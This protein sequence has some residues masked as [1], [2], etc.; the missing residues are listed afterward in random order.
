MKYQQEY[1]EQSA[2]RYPESIAVDDHGDV[3]NYLELDTKANKLANLLR[4]IKVSTNDR[5]CLY[6]DKNI[7]MYTSV[8]G[9]LKSGGCWV[10]FSSSFPEERV[11]FLLSTLKPK[12]VLTEKK[13]LSSIKQFKKLSDM[14]FSIIVMEELDEDD[15]EVFDTTNIEEQSSERPKSYSTYNDLAYIIFTSGSTGT[16][17]GVMVEHRNTSQFLSLSK[18]YFKI[19]Q[20]SR[21][22]HFSELTFDPS[23]FD[24]FYCW[25]TAG[26][27]VPFNKKKYKINPLLFFQE[28]N[29]NVLF[30]VPGV[31]LNISD[32]GQL[33]NKSLHT[34]KHLLL[35][36][37]AVPAKLISDWYECHPESTVYNMYGTTETAI[38]S[39][40]YK[41]P[42]GFSMDSEVPVGEVL[43]ETRVVLIENNK[44]VDDGDVGECVVSSSQLSPGY[45]GNKFLTSKLFRENIGNNDLPQKSYW[46]GDLLRKD[47]NDLYYY[48]G[49][50]DTQLKI[51][52]HRVELGEVENTIL[53]NSSVVEAVVLP[54]KND[55]KY[56]EYLVAY[57]KFIKEKELNELLEFIASRLPSY[58]VPMKIIP[59]NDDFPRN[60]NGKIDRK[61]LLE[62]LSEN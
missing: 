26:T 45:W 44:K 61:K 53:L 54:V 12:A 23:I 59:V 3:I 28:N 11:L 34:V 4:T 37:E 2:A 18:D 6:I 62:D 22:A 36:G 1:F 29:I 38:V 42:I 50:K 55:R 8:L 14:D 33:G 21:F 46:T 20:G 13:Y 16:P 15:A 52:G 40:W 41:F 56:A 32:S 31:L 35:T 25:A 17:K 10:P 7:S 5:V 24:M 19:E 27:L 57:V 47:Q 60:T 48:V 43:P 51:R 49:R 30:T 39:H 58:M 9:V